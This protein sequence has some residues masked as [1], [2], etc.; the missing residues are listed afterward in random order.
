[1]K[2]KC[3]NCKRPIKGTQTLPFECKC[4]KLVSVK[5]VSNSEKEL[6]SF[7]KY[8]Q[9]YPTQR[10]WQALINWYG[11][12]LYCKTEWFNIRGKKV[13]EESFEDMFYK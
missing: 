4:G 11:K 5:F 8:C 6:E 3:P 13:I 2:Y 1:M 9:R 12:D 10:F 7:I